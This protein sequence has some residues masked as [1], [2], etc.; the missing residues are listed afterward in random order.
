MVDPI[1]LILIWLAGLGGFS[2]RWSW[3]GGISYL[4]VTA[5]LIGGSALA[6]QP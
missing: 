2:H 6:G 1:L 5:L 4:M 3:L